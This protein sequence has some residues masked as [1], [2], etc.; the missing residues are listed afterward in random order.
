MM[1]LNTT[2]TFQLKRLGSSHG[3]RAGSGRKDYGGDS[4]SDLGTSRSRLSMS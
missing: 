1:A 4:D 2:C 3:N